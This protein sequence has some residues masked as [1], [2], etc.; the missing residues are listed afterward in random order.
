[1]S[2][3]IFIGFI[4]LVE[5]LKTLI[6]KRIRHTTIRKKGYPPENCDVDGNSIIE[7]DTTIKPIN[8]D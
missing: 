1:L 6:T 7:I 3:I 2:L 4:Y 8:K 5:S